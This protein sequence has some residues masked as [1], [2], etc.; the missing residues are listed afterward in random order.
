MPAS[1][2]DLHQAEEK[3]EHRHQAEGDIER[4][5]RVTQRRVG[6]RLERH[7]A[8]RF[9]LCVIQRH[10]V[11]AVLLQVPDHRDFPFFLRIARRNGSDLRS[12][13]ATSR[14]SAGITTALFAVRKRKTLLVN[15][16]ILAHGLD[17]KEVCACFQAPRSVMVFV[18]A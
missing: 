7:E 10:G 17:L 3:H 5:F 4:R 14:Y 18:G 2:A 1:I 8:A 15:L 13:R 9:D 6:Q 11:F 16:V 12:S